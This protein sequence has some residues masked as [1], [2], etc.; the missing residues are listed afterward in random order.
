MRSGFDTPVDVVGGRMGLKYVVIEN[1]QT[2][3]VATY[4][5]SYQ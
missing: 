4:L 5:A 1:C 2:R 3:A